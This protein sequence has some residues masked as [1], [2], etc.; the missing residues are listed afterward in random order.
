M[1]LLK[2][3]EVVLVLVGSVPDH[4]FE[5]LREGRRTTSQSKP[6]QVIPSRYSLPN[7]LRSRSSTVEERRRD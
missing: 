2:I 3:L 4:D 7:E 1:K 6:T 5:A